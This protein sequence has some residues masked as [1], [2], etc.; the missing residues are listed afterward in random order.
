[1]SVYQRENLGNRPWIN[2]ILFLV[3]KSLANINCLFACMSAE[4]EE[5]TRVDRRVIGVEELESDVSFLNIFYATIFLDKRPLFYKKIFFYK[6]WPKDN[7]S[8][9][10][11]ICDHFFEIVSVN[12]LL[13]VQKWNFY[14]KELSE[15]ADER[16]LYL[17]W[18]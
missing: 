18:S 1:M 10:I 5:N 9:G 6:G 15:S 8:R 2:H 7:R 3:E 11:R 17:F 16:Y 14:E 4:G 12:S 13:I